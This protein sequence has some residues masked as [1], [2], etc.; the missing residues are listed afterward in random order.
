MSRVFGDNCWGYA[1]RGGGTQILPRL[2]GDKKAKELSFS[3]DF[4]SAEEALRPR[5]VNRGVP[6]E[7]L[8]DTVEELIGEL[9][10]KSSA[11]LRFA[12]L[13]VNRSLETALS[14]G[15]TPKM[16]FV[17]MCWSTQDQKEGA[18][19]FLEKRA[20]VYSGE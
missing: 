3:G 1:E 2:V 7:K 16:D 4:V 11:T 6:R 15:I 10:S 20:P 8:R 17:A 9:R 5:R 12:K 19:A 13:S 18:K 14:I